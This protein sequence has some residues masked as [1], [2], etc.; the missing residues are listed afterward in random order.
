VARTTPKVQQETLTWQH[1]TVIHQLTVGTVDWYAWLEQASTFAFAG[2]TGTFTARKE[3]RQRG[4]A[5][6]KAYRKRAG[7]L[8]RAYLGKSNELTLAR[9]QMVATALAEDAARTDS[10]SKTGEQRRDEQQTWNGMPSPRILQPPQME[11]VGKKPR[12]SLLPVPLTPLIGR[13]EE[14]AQVCTLLKQPQVRLVTLVGPGG[15]GKTRLALQVAVDAGDAF[16]GG[17]FFVPLAS[18]RDHQLVIATIA[19][20]LGLLASDRSSIM[21]QVQGYA[22]DKQLLLILDNLEHLLV[23]Q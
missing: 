19:Q 12:Q 9:L 21:D 14:A 20:T 16:P 3:P 13:E 6:W 4:G 23:L 11:P 10:S 17:V 2:P 22:Q 7:K 1:G 8:R 18:I 5:Y 15:V